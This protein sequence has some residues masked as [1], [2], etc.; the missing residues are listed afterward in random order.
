MIL[1]EKQLVG[2]LLELLNILKEYKEDKRTYKNL[3]QLSQDKILDD[4]DLQVDLEIEGYMIPQVVVDF[5]S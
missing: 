1:K 3:R 2:R 5:R 4:Y